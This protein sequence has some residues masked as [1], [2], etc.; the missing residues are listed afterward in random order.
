[1]SRFASR[2]GA[3]AAELHQLYI[4]NHPVELQI[5]PDLA[6]RRGMVQFTTAANLEN[7]VIGAVT[8]TFVTALGSPAANNVHIKV[9]SSV[10]ET[11]KK[12]SLATYGTVDATNIAYGTGTSPHP[13]ARAFWT[14]VRYNIG[15]TAITAGNNLLVLETAE[16]VIT[17]YTLTSTATT[18][19]TAMVREGSTRYVFTGNTTPAGESIRGAKQMIVPV[20]SIREQGIG[21]TPATSYHLRAIVITSVSATG[22]EIESDWYWSQDEVTYT[23]IAKGIVTSKDT[24]TSG[25]FVAYIDTFE[26]PAGAELYCQMGT[27][28]TSPTAWVEI[29]V[30]IAAGN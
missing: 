18:S 20:S 15:S 8:Y 21:D 19:V 17:A 11:I 28:G 14:S 10:L 9:Q 1:M 3:S 5:V 26:V 2:G 22:L 23:R 24:A 13:T 4:A 30:R 12:L 16:D 25:A 6:S 29:R 27:D 7:C